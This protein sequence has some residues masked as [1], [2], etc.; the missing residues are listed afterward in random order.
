MGGE[1]LGGLG[2]S[3]E[4]LSLATPTGSSVRSEM[5]AHCGPT[6]PWWRCVCGTA[7]STTERCPLNA[8]PSW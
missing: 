1:G 4:V 8:S 7:P 5:P 2:S 3:F 6:T